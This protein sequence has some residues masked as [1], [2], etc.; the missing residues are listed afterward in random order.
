MNLKI[1]PIAVLLLFTTSCF[2]QD[3][4]GPDV[5]D[6]TKLTFLNPGITYEKRVAKFQTLYA[7]AF[8]N[9]SAY[10]TYSSYFGSDAAIYFDPAL[11]LQYRFY[12]NAKQRTAKNR[13]TEMNSLNYVAP[14]YEVV[15]SKRRIDESYY[16]EESRRAINNLGVVWGFQRNYKKRFSLDL[17]LGLCYLFAKSSTLDINSQRVSSTEGQISS[18]AQINLGFWLNRKK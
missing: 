6:V 16:D 12:Y 9:T 13:R 11:S 5:T 8:M 14:I 4:T 3:E 18:I 1:L 10:Y 7:Q 17:Y 15:F 2:S